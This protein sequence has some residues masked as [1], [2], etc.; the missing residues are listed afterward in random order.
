MA[1]EVRRTE[2]FSDWLRRLRD[3]RARAKA[4]KRLERLADG[5]PGD[6]RPAGGGISEMR[7]DYGPG[8]RLYYVQL[9]DTAVVLWGGDKDTQDRDIAKANELLSE[10][11][12]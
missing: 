7:I 4:L 6:V 11:K 8:Y 2:E 9:G 12:E 5:N 1:I 3:P 10:Y